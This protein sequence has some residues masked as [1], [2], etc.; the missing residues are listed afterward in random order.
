MSLWLSP[1]G[2]L[3]PGAP[4]EGLDASLAASLHGDF[5]VGSGAGLFLLGARE[6]GSL[7]PPV[8]AYWRDFGARYVAALCLR[9]E[10]EE[11]PP[12]LAPP[13]DL[14]SILLTAPPMPGGEYLSVEV[15]AALWGEMDRAFHALHSAS[16]TSLQDFLKSLNPAW[17]RV[18]RV[19]FNLAENRKDE[20]HP[21][22]FLATYTGQFSSTGKVQHLPLGQ[23]L[24]DYAGASNKD[25][26]LSLLVPVQRAAERCP[27]LKRMVDGGEIFH[28]LRWTPAQAFR[29]LGDVPHLEHAGVVVRMPATWKAGRPSRPQ[30]SASVGT[31]APSAFGLA[32]MLDFS[33]AL[34]LDGEELTETEVQ[35]LLK[36][37]QGLALIRGQWVEVDPERL[38][39]TMARFQEAQCLAVKG[40][41]SFAEAMRML[42]GAAIGKAEAMEEAADWSRITAGPWLEELL[43]GLRSP[44]SLAAIDPGPALKGTLRPYQQ[45]GLRWLHLLSSLGLGACLADDMGLGKTIQIIALLLSLKQRGPSLLVA[46]G[47][48]PGQ[49]GFGAG[50]L[51]A[52][53]RGA[54]HPP[55]SSERRGPPA[56]K[57]HSASPSCSPRG[58]RAKPDDPVCPQ[59]HPLE[60]SSRGSGE[61]GSRHHQLRNPAADS[62]D[63]GNRMELGHPG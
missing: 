33:L 37:T 47:L 55:V 28:P 36:A 61:P 63:V 10:G 8:L 39:R 24:R 50:T 56:R 18:G 62:L 6:I 14:P 41:L 52:E 23:A 9:P 54:D 12:R 45:A 20:D 42:S 25:R 15:L 48:P 35:E 3:H 57:A 5:E 13:E 60:E 16:R 43:K 30:V 38:E 17:N 1:R 2:H 11:A 59:R 4:E 58:V 34:S 51:R 7:L 46:P 31:K 19:N 44:E 26:L 32:A 40:G 22:A 29:F 21:F 53:P 27:W 49:L